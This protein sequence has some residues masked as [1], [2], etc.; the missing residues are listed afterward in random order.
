MAEVERLVLSQFR[1][2]VEKGK[3]ALDNVDSAGE[4]APEPMRKA[5]QNLIKEGERALKKIEPVSTATHEEYGSNFINAVK[6]ND[7]IAQFRSELED[8]LWD[9]DD[10]VE[11]DEFDLDKFNDLQKASRNTA[12]K[13]LDILKRMKLVAA[14][15]SAVS[16]RP[17]SEASTSTS[18]HG[19]LGFVS[20]DA[21]P[22]GRPPPTPPM[23]NPWQVGRAVSTLGVHLEE[24]GDEPHLPDAPDSPTIPPA[25][26]KSQLLSP[27]DN[28]LSPIKSRELYDDIMDEEH[29]QRMR[30]ASQSCASMSESGGLSSPW[31]QSFRW[32]NST[33]A[34]NDSML[35]PSRAQFMRGND[36]STLHPNGHEQYAIRRVPSGAS[37]VMI[38]R[39]PSRSRVVAATAA[40]AGRDREPSQAGLAGFP[41]RST[42]VANQDSSYVLDPSRP[43]T[44]SVNSSVFDV[45]ES[46]S[47]TETNVPSMYRQSAMST[48]SASSTHS[49]TSRLALPK[50]PGPPGP[51]PIYSTP[52]VPPRRTS[53]MTVMSQAT[54]MHTAPTEYSTRGLDEGLIPVD[55]DTNIPT[56]S[57]IPPRETDC[58]ISPASSFYK[59]KGFCKGAEE[60]QR[61]QLG[62]KK[63]KRPVGGFSNATVAK[64]NHCLFELDF[65]SVEQDLNNESSGSFTSNTLGFR[66]RILQKSHMPI[67]VIEEQMYGCVFCI[68]AGHTIEESDATVF[69]SQ[70]QLFT[71]YARHARPLPKVAGITVI[72]EPELPPQLK[73][74]FDLHFPYPPMESVMT[75][76]AR[77]IARLPRAVATDARKVFHGAQRLPPD[78]LPAL[79]LAVGAKIVG[80]EFPTKYD[81]KW[82]IGWHDGARA[83]FELDSV[84]LEAPSKAEVRMQG[85]SSVQAV[86]RWAW[87]QKGDD[88][89]LKF[90]KGDVIKNIS[91]VYKDHWCWS[92][93]TSKGCGVFPASHI[94]PESVRTVDSEK[95]SIVSWEKK[96]SKNPLMFSLR[97]KKDKTLFAQ[98]NN[99][100]WK[101]NVY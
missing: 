64:C 84:Q 39:P 96:P 8:L 75:G 77:E 22:D 80:I 30:A 99:S 72:E 16:S 44:E 97:S 52:P 59:L 57:M 20:T 85:T 33:M 4:N 17:L 19:S 82:A 95:A 76:I 1:E 13:I 79:Q 31:Q 74:N 71:H 56:D 83:A 26:P 92:G 50:Y 43:S 23:A 29:E 37:S 61:G 10:Y 6:E 40:A 69:F 81:G 11:V 18:G 68:Q 66:L 94:D 65:K 70:K 41:P 98:E 73:D 34:S 93:T 38:G 62:F 25:Q 87:K 36:T 3:V 88:R 53:G 47:P 12:L 86:A 21:S 78:R 35:S 49:A 46:L 5:A 63:I 28:M 91:W 27:G 45:V 60:A 14:P 67:R 15:A 89:W 42:S 58:T 101:S 9:F 55:S 2:I 54:T 51:P 24:G 90:D 32:T 100:T 48:I 7:E